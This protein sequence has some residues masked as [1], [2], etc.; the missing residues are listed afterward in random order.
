MDR[1]QCAQP[2]HVDCQSR[3]ANGL[4]M[5]A[6]ERSYPLC[7]NAR[8]IEQA[9]R[10]EELQAIIEITNESDDGHRIYHQITGNN[11]ELRAE[12]D[13]LREKLQQV[14]DIVKGMADLFEVKLNRKPPANA[15]EK[16][17]EGA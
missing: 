5:S 1:Y 8:I 13:E 12:N 2:G 9:E 6:N 17:E 10:I 14:E 3:H 4:C 15:D 7:A 11:R 16:P